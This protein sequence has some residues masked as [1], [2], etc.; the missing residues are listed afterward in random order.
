M[1]VRRRGSRNVD[2][3]V[4]GVPQPLLER[5]HLLKGRYETYICY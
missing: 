4:Q 2:L 5:A 1:G 3:L